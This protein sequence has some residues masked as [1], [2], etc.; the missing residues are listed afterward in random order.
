MQMAILTSYILF[1]IC[2]CILNNK[3]KWLIEVIELQN[4]FNHEVADTLERITAIHLEE[5]EKIIESMEIKE[6]E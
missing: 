6:E 2:I 5:E 1:L 3:I 4:K